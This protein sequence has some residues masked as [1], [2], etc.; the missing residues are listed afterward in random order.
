[1]FSR[2]AKTTLIL[3][4]CLFG[5][6]CLANRLSTF[7]KYQ[8]YPNKDE[9]EVCGNI[10]DIID[11][12]SGRYKKILVRNTNS[13]VVFKDEDCRRMTSRT[14]SKLDVLASRVRGLWN[15]VYLKVIL[16]W[17]DKT[18]DNPHRSL[19][20]E[21]SYNFQNFICSNFKRKFVLV[22]YFHLS[23]EM[24]LKNGLKISK[25]FKL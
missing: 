22:F 6:K 11:R 1:M 13:E 15:G 2:L 19:H 5:L 21:G 20:Y 9:T 12:D 8:K 3:F 25:L 4:T 17:T 14:K 23:F 16:A 24:L 7:S 18:F 10:R